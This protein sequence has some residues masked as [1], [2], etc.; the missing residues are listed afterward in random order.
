M[1]VSISEF[2]SSI[3]GLASLVSAPSGHV[4]FLPESLVIS[5]QD[6]HIPGKKNDS[7][8]DLNSSISVAKRFGVS[9]D[10]IMWQQTEGMRQAQEKLS[11]T[12]ASRG[13]G[14]QQRAQQQGGTH[15]PQMAR[16]DNEQKIRKQTFQSGDR[17]EPIPGVSPS[18]AERSNH[19]GHGQSA[20][21]EHRPKLN[22]QVPG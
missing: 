11:A 2:E 21:I 5:L 8:V 14:H 18:P 20:P 15:S 16:L 7:D 6:K 9:R 22:V 3:P 17:Y 10:E 4:L 13:P 1:K 12:A 19:R